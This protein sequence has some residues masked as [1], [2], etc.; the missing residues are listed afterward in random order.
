M[1]RIFITR[2]MVG[3]AELNLKK[4][5]LHVKIYKEDHPIPKEELIKRVKDVDALI[6]HVTDRIDKEVID[7]MN[8]C[9]VISNYAVGYNNIDV[10]YA[11]SKGI[12]VTNTPNILTDSTADIAVALVLACARRLRDGEMLMRSGKFT[13]YKPHLL[14]GIE[15]KGKT[16]GIIGAGGIGFATA[17]RLQGFGTK[18]IYFNRSRNEKFENE[19]SANR[20][21][22]NFL[23][24]SSDIISVHLPSLKE[25]FHILNKTN[26]KLMK[27]TAILV[28]TSRGEIIEER[29]LIEMLKKKKIFAAGFD[30]YEGEPNVNPELFKL[31]NVFL[32]PHIGS[33]TIEARSAIAELC[34]KNVIAVL[35]GNKPITPVNLN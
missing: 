28:N 22:L 3:N 32:L 9:K 27:K 21:S 10:E 15:L 14:L 8:K 35:G 17:K 6:C 25:T 24:K 19:L 18:I 20:V 13:G 16:V 11:N 7:S 23:L 5:E 31:E 29:Y 2:K 4:K 1:K 26:L 33:A 12:I 30:V 34:I